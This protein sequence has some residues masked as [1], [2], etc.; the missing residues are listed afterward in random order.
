MINET[1]RDINDYLRVGGTQCAW[2]G[3]S[4]PQKY[5]FPIMYH[6]PK[7]KRGGDQQLHVVCLECIA[8]ENTPKGVS[9]LDLPW[10]HGS[11]KVSNEKVALSMFN[12]SPAR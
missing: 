10:Y 12:P 9:K 5:L 7:E 8:A 4:T 2:C 11:K 6:S 3:R 1:K